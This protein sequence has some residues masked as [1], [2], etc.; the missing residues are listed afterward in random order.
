MVAKSKLPTP[1]VAE[2]GLKGAIRAA[3]KAVVSTLGIAATGGNN[4]RLTYH[5]IRESNAE[6]GH[7]YYRTFPYPDALQGDYHKLFTAAWLGDLD[8]IKKLTIERDGPNQVHICS[9]IAGFTAQT[10]LQV[11]LVRGHY[12]LIS[13]MVEIAKKQYTPLPEPKKGN[14]PSLV[15]NNYQINNYNLV[16]Q[17]PINPLVGVDVSQYDPNELAKMKFICTN[18]PA[19]LFKVTDNR[20]YNLLQTGIM[21][22]NA[23]GLAAVIKAALTTENHKK[24]PKHAGKSED[25]SKQMPL[26]EH[27]LRAKVGQLNAFELAI[28]YG[29]RYRYLCHCCQCQVTSSYLISFLTMTPF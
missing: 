26:L 21:L 12:H 6:E 5:S 11:A 18:S 2:G 22:Q 23:E 1:P 28:A 9:K 29:K 14:Q 10:P 8:T 27:L 24:K 15:N 19:T 17:F 7:S 20:G 4:G 16:N 13:E 25:A 3:M